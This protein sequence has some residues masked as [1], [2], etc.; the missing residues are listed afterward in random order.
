MNNISSISDFMTQLRLA[1]CRNEYIRQSGDISSRD[2]SFDDR[3]ELIFLAEIND[4]ATRRVRRLL[5]EASLKISA[6]PSGF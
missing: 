4:R 6:A 5:S 3:L 1:S 2:M